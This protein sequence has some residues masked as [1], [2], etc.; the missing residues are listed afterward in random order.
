MA[1]MG[2]DQSTVIEMMSLV[3]EH[4]DGL[5]EVNYVKICNA[6]R[7]LHQ[8]FTAPQPPPPPPPQSTPQPAPRPAPRP[9]PRPAPQPAPRPVPRPTPLRE[10][11]WPRIRLE[12]LERSAVVVINAHRQKVIEELMQHTLTGPRG[13]AIVLKR[14]QIDQY[15]E[16]FIDVG[17]IHDQA[18]FQRLSVMKAKEERDRE[19]HRQRVHLNNERTRLENLH[20]II[21]D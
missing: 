5:K 3:D 14:V 17:L 19:I 4:R 20:R 16:Q 6:M 18:E 2:F 9:V 1:S 11:E 8:H 15:V 12:R 7:Y 10:L 21:I 13:G